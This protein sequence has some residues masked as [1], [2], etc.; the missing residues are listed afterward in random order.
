MT[1]S[2]S[3]LA[4]PLHGVNVEL[5]GGSATVV[6]VPS[7]IVIHSV[8]ADATSVR[9]H[10]TSSKQQGCF[11]TLS[12]VLAV[13]CRTSSRNISSAK[14]VSARTQL[15]TM[16]THRFSVWSSPRVFRLLAQSSW[17]GS[18]DFQAARLTSIFR[19][20]RFSSGPQIQSIWSSF[21]TP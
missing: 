8:P 15:L 1:T 6:A 19:R 21:L 2:E 16:V 14:T 11:A 18:R 7:R 5:L 9:L 3:A 13:L 10:C 12:F 17:A 4:S 20:P